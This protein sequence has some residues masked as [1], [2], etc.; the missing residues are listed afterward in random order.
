MATRVP[1]DFQNVAGDLDCHHADEA[2]T[3][4]ATTVAKIR[5]W[6]PSTF[7]NRHKGHVETWTHATGKRSRIDYFATSEHFRVGDVI[8]N[9]WPEFDTLA[10]KDDMRHC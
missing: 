4:L 1:V 5:H 8:R 10:N 2:G 7:S 6:M 3:R 9:P